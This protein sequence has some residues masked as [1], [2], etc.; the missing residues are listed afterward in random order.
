MQE[1]PLRMYLNM[2]HAKHKTLRWPEKI[3]K[4]NVAVER[5]KCTRVR[6]GQGLS[7]VG[8]YCALC[9]AC[10][11]VLAPTKSASAMGLH[12]HM[13]P[14]PNTTNGAPLCTTWRMGTI[15]V[16]AGQ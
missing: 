8:G 9:F 12:L 14:S 7:T 16:Q 5:L 15:G 13:V 11:A 2:Y 1:T 4:N 3:N 10:W 6:K